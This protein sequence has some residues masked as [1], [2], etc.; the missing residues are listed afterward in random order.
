MQGILILQ[1]IYRQLLNKSNAVFLRLF[2]KPFNVLRI[3]NTDD[4]IEML[5]FS[6][7]QTQKLS[8]AQQLRVRLCSFGWQNL[9]I[10]DASEWK[11][12]AVKALL[13]LLNKHKNRRAYRL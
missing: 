5:S 7:I 8:A 9:L 4:C 3:N 2:W 12:L 11:T 13:G 6:N 10:T 1:E